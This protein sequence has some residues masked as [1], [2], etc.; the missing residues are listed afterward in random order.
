MI[1]SLI[2]CMAVIIIILITYAPNAKKILFHLSLLFFSTYYIYI[3]VLLME[4]HLVYHHIYIHQM[5]HYMMLDFIYFV[6]LVKIVL[7]II[8]VM[9]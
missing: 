6:K 3:K 4:L 8:L 7:Y 2:V 5:I 1:L 9:H